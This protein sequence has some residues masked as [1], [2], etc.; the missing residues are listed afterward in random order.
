M[1]HEPPDHAIWA[2]LLLTCF[3][4]GLVWA[5]ELLSRLLR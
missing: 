4:V 3:A 1:N 5:I 2:M